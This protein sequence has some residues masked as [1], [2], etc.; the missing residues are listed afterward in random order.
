M[1]NTDIKTCLNNLTKNGICKDYVR[2]MNK[3]FNINTSIIGSKIIVGINI[4]TI[5]E[6][7]DEEVGIEF[8]KNIA[9]H[10]CNGKG[11][12]GFCWYF[13]RKNIKFL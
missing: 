11:K 1:I 2:E 5:I 4:G 13:L 7:R 8:E 9:G 6:E 10:G 3:K 12:Y